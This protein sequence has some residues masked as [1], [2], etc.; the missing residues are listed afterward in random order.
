M[1]LQKRYFLNLVSWQGLDILNL[2]IKW[3]YFS[4]FRPSVEQRKVRSRDAAR[5][6]RSQET[7]VFYELAHS[8]PLPRR[9]ASHLDKAAIMRVALSYLRMN[10]LIQSG[11]FFWN[12]AGNCMMCS[13]GPQLVAQNS[14]NG[15]F[16][17][18]TAGGK[19]CEMSV[20][21]ASKYN[22]PGGCWW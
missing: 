3:V 6:R 19:Q 5:C 20:I 15:G 4:L 8:L 21:S 9:I 22:N 1:S 13:S 11:G 2:D 10:R 7:E 16:N 17:S 14:Q 18:F 12:Q